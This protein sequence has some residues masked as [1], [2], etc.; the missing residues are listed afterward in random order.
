MNV[1]VVLNEDVC[2]V[3][4]AKNS[5][6]ID[7]VTTHIKERTQ[8]MNVD[9]SMIVC[10]TLSPVS[11]AQYLLFSTPHHQSSY[12]KRRTE[13][14]MENTRARKPTDNMA[15]IY[16]LTEGE[17]TQRFLGMRRMKT[18]TFTPPSKHMLK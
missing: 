15:N 13:K 5:G 12:E 17:L 6:N 16:P 1:H 14:H 4:M 18:H 9:T 8:T 11:P 3:C 7:N 10:L 2:S